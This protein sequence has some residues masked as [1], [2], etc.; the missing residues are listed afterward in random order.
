[1]RKQQRFGQLLRVA[2]IALAGLALPALAGAATND[3]SLALE[4]SYDHSS[5]YLFRGLDLLAGRPVDPGHVGVG[6]EG[7]EVYWWGYKGEY[8]EWAAA[9]AGLAANRYLEHDF[10]VEYGWEKARATWTVGAVAYTYQDPA[11]LADT[12]EL[13]AI[14]G[15]GG[16]LSPTFSLYY[17]VDV[18]DGGYA[19]LGIS[20]AWELPHGLALTPSAA[21]GHSLGWTGRTYL[22]GND[23]NPNDFQ[24]GLDVRWT[25][26]PFALHATAQRS[27]ALRALED[28]GQGDITAYTVG[29]AY[30]F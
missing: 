15:L 27:F 8:P 21:Y 2:A 11:E 9:A 4:V 1:M 10:G 19:S 20:H 3:R 22:Q 16:F 24:L 23:W 14:A 13:Y 18:Y 12:V 29:G 28:V 30:S 6:W 7:L 25:R 5:R 26:G 17:D